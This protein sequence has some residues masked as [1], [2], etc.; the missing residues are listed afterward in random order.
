MSNPKLRAQVIEPYTTLLYLGREYPMGY[1]YF[2][3]RCKAAFMK[4]KDKTDE[5]EIKMLIARGQFV[6]KEIE[7]LYMLRKYRT[8]KKR[9]YE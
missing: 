5:E 7:A 1:P 8:L 2:R 4:N 3:D 6:V 9:Y